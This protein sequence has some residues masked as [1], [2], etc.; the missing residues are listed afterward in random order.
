MVYRS[1]FANMVGYALGNNTFPLAVSVRLTVQR[2]LKF[3]KGGV[4]A[5][6]I[7]AGAKGAVCEA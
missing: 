1:F 6:E 5:H 4:D 2:E 7:T 3:P